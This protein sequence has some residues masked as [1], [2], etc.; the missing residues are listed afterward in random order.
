MKRHENF[1]FIWNEN[2]LMKK[3]IETSL[4]IEKQIKE[5]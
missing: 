5:L 3:M 1:M 2:D 4:L